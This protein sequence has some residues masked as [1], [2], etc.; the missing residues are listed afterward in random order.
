MTDA[1]HLYKKITESKDALPGS[2]RKVADYILRN[3]REVAFLTAEELAKRTGVSL[4]TVV[5]TAA[6]L[7]FESYQVLRELLADVAK[8]SYSPTW[9]ELEDSWRN[10]DSGDY[11]G[12]VVRDTIEA[13]RH[14]LTPG[15]AASVRNAVEILDGARVVHIMGSRSSRA[16]ALSLYYAFQQFLRDARLL[17]TMGGDDLYE[18]LLRVREKDAFIAISNGYPHYAV[19]TLDAV[20]F[21]GERGVPV[22]LVTDSMSNPA[23]PFCREVIHVPGCEAH[24]SLIPLMAVLDAVVVGMGRKRSDEAVGSLRSLW[25]ILIENGITMRPD[26]EDKRRKPQDNR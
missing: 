25:K 24:F 6:G 1:R 23:I 26:E 16:P 12:M 13:L 4:A 14:I 10:P 19:Q 17:G 22:V 15:V 3:G 20:R 8:A 2:Q 21:V 7:G 18:N 5:R 11:F 9:R